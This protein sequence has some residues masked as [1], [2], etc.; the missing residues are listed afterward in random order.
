LERIKKTEDIVLDVLE[1]NIRA[2]KD[3]FVLYGAVL[4][5]LGVDLKVQ[6]CEFLANAKENKMPSFETVTRCRRHIQELR[7]DLT[8]T[9]TAISREEN[10]ERFK[11]YNLSDVRSKI[12]KK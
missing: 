11:E 6:L 7:T 10:I 3:D 8:D 12:C 4:R 1:N 5:R 2:R 9:K